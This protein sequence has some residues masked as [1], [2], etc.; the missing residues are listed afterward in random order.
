MKSAALGKND[1]D[2]QLRLFEIQRRS[3]S[4]LRLEHNNR[5]ER[6][7]SRLRW[8][9]ERIDDLDKLPSKCQSSVT[10]GRRAAQPDR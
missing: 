9:K 3:R 5:F 10:R 2:L 7:R 1:V 8:A 6:S 4:Y